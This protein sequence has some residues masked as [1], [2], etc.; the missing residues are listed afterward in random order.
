MVFT[1]DNPVHFCALQVLDLK[2]VDYKQE[3][4]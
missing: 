1:K 4:I 3:Y 2:L